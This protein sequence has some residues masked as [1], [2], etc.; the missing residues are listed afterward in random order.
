MRLFS[1]IRALVTMIVLATH[2]P[3]GH[4]DQLGLSLFIGRFTRVAAA[5]EFDPTRSSQTLRAQCLARNE[6]VFLYFIGG[7]KE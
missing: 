4:A 7:A 2:T 1:Q 5:Q 3:M 6:D